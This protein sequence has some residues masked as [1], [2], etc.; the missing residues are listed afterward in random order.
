MKHVSTF[1]NFL[2]IK[3]V[4]L[5]QVLI[6]QNFIETLAMNKFYTTAIAISTL[7]LFNSCRKDF[8]ERIIG[9]W[10]LEDIDRRGWGGSTSNLAFQN[11]TFEFQEG[12]ALIYTNSFGQVYKGSWDVREE[13]TYDSD[14]NGKYTRALEINAINFITQDVRTEYFNEIVF[15]VNNTLKAFIYSGS[16]TYVYRFER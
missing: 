10:D 15:K 5:L 1:Q 3:F 8:S 11:G 16:K 4:L 7:V 2:L 12:G 6:D 13:Q 14:G 9:T